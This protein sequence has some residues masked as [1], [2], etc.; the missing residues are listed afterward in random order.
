MPVIADFRLALSIDELLRYQGRAAERPEVKAL[1]QWA[2]DEAQRLATPAMAYEWF[3]VHA[4][5]GET[6]RIGDALL[7]L[8]PHADL[9]APAREAWVSVCTIGS[10]LE[11]QVETLLAGE[12]LFE[13]YLLD[14]VGVMA[15]AATAEPLR[16]I[17][18]KEAAR[19]GWGVSLVLSPGSLVGWTISDQKVL[20]ALLDLRAIGVNVTVAGILA[21]QKSGTGLVGIGPDYKTQCVGSA[22]QFC[23]LRHTCWRRH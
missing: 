8:G 18:E 10:A 16:H 23:A 22:C 20:C 19:R 21:P 11:E 14:A 9:L 5:E 1:A 17:V 15:L 12:R 3:P 2:I 4:V 7:H 13:G 6:A